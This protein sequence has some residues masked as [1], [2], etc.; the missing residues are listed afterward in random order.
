MP[1]TKQELIVIP[2][3]NSPDIENVLDIIHKYKGNRD[4]LLVDTQSNNEEYKD[5][6]SKKCDE[7]GFLW[8]E[9]D[10]PDYEHSAVKTAIKYFPRERYWFQHDSLIPK[11]NKSYD[12]VFKEIKKGVAVAW[13]GFEK[14][15]CPFM[16]VASENFCVEKFG[17]LDYETGV[18]GSI[19]GITRNDLLKFDEINDNL[20]ITNKTEA[21]TMER[22]WAILFKRYK[23][24]PKYIEG[25]M[26]SATW[27]KFHNDEF[28]L[29]SKRFGNRQ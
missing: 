27:Y 10:S 18:F 15:V 11:T 29:F 7:C 12:K 2:T 1:K 26:T 19:F 20:A 9:S 24:E 22:A 25:I 28:L 17:S 13:L 21:T 4:V 6:C 5:L 8:K 23:I 16:N 14:A 3:N